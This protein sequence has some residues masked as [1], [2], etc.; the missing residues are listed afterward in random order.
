MASVLAE[1]L[2]RLEGVFDPPM[3]Y[4][5]WIHQRPTDGGDWPAAW[6]HVEI[7]G[8]HRAPGVMRYVAGAELVGVPA[9]GEGLRVD[10]LAD[11]LARGDGD[12]RSHSDP[13]GG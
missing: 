11:R 5:F 3:P 7:A 1:T 10:V 13:N 12:R 6:M 4:M 9:D 2:G 8:P